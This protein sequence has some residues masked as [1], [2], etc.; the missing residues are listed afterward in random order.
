MH[1]GDV[2]AGRALAQRH[3]QRVEDE[4][5]GDDSSSGRAPLSASAWGTRLRSASGW[6]PRSW[7][8]WAIGRSPLQ[9]QPHAALN[10]LIG[11]LLRTGHGGGASPPARTEP[12]LR[13]LRETRSGSVISALTGS[14]TAAWKTALWMSIAAS[15]KPPGGVDAEATAIVTSAPDDAASSHPYGLASAPH[16]ATHQGG[17]FS[18][19]AKGSTFDRP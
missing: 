7:A 16:T 1:E 8:M 18:T 9:R 2:G 19:G 6:M 15:T 4:G 11:I 14:R 10:Q 17:H 5:G 3:P 12:S 13:G